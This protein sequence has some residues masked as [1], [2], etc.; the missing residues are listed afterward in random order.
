MEWQESYGGPDDDKAK[1]I[2]QSSDGTFLIIGKSY[3]NSG[4]ITDHRGQ[5]DAWVVK[6]DP[7]GGLLWT[8]SYGGSLYDE[9][10][11]VVQTPDLGYVI[12]CSS[13]SSDMDV[14]FNKGQE[15]YWLIKISPAGII[16]WQ[17]NYGGSLSDRPSSLIT[18]LDGGFLISGT[19][20]S[21]DMDVSGNHGAD[22]FWIVK[23]DNT[24]TLMWQKC[25]G[26]SLSDE[27][28][29][30][31]ATVDN[32]IVV[33]GYVQSLDGDVTNLRGMTD[34]WAA[35]LTPGGNLINARSLGGSM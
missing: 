15:D 31:I 21:N 5:Y 2:I 13:N 19:S 10:F 6:I 9:S 18:T 24:G 3:S 7:A 14:A 8:K 25:L 12:A 34:Y 1:A 11:S 20:S 32:N 26:G 22:D 30:L 16:Q 23:V 27:C 4:M 17:Q 28:T 33:S 35:K 29:S